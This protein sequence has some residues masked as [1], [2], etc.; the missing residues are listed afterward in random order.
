[1]AEWYRRDDFRQVLPELLKCEDPAL[2]GPVHRLAVQ[3]GMPM[4]P[5]ADNARITGAR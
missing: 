3:S 5:L 4:P 1:M 2:V